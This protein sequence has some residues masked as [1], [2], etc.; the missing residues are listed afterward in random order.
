MGARPYVPALGRFLGVDPIEGGSANDYDY[1]NGDPVNGLDLSGLGPCL[2]F[3]H[4]ER[5]DGSHYCKGN[6]AA[7]PLVDAF[8]YAT[9]ADLR[10]QERE[11][12]ACGCEVPNTN[13]L[14]GAEKVVA[15]RYVDDVIRVGAVG[16]G[17]AST[18]VPQLAGVSAFLSLA[19]PVNESACP[20]AALTGQVAG[21]AVGL[22]NA[23]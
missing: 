9:N 5:S 22:V 15:E 20:E 19:I 21:A 7:A 4:R 1:T 6:A 10:R 14:A 23:L 13:P 2:P 8:E 12:Y 18:V 3:T 11:S 17:L 16:T